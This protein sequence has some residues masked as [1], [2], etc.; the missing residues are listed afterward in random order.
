MHHTKNSLSEPVRTQIC[1]MLQE[2]LS[3]SIDLTTQAKQ[4]HWN[5]KGPDFISLHELFDK[6]ATSSGE[7]VDSIAER[8]MQLGGLAEGI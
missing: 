4:A 5:V 7:Y 8:I 1:E 6:I 3:N 2:H